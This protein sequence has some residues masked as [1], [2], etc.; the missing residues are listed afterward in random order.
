MEK[1]NEEGCQIYRPHEHSGVGNVNTHLEYWSHDEKKWLPITEEVLG[2]Q[3]PL[4]RRVTRIVEG[5]Y[6]DP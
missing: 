2:V 1:C 6:L 3:I 4:I 5:I